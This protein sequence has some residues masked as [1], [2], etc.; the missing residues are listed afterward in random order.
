MSN[1]LVKHNLRA[2]EH[3]GDADHVC[4]FRSLLAQFRD[5]CVFVAIQTATCGSV[6]QTEGLIAPEHTPRMVHPALIVI[7][8]ESKDASARSDYLEGVIRG[9]TAS[10]SRYIH[11]IIGYTGAHYELYA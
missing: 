10:T 1:H 3:C 8:A 4:A 2:V 11:D 5:A 7:A 6:I 9:H